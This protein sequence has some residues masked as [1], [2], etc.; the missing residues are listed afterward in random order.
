MRCSYG[1]GSSG[2]FCCCSCAAAAAGGGG[3][4]DGGGG[5]GGGGGNGG[6]A[7]AGDDTGCGSCFWESFWPP[8]NE[9]FDPPVARVGTAR[10]GPM[11]M[12]VLLQVAE[13]EKHSEV[14]VAACGWQDAVD[15]NLNKTEERNT[16][17]VSQ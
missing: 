8:A 14:A 17:A 4:G 6:D 5:D 11:L 13:A 2:G 7:G 16:S 3:G 9:G 10:S 1:H 15:R 12:V